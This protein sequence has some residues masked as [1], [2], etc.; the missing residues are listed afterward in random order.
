MA[1]DFKRI[2]IT[3]PEPRAGQA[4]AISAFLEAGGH[5]AHL[6]FPGAPESVMRRAI[7]EIAEGLRRR[8]RLHSHFSLAEEYGL[9]GV[10]LNS[11]WPNA[12]A[13]VAYSASCHSLEE[14]AS[15]PGADYVTLSP[16]Y[17][18]ISKSGYQGRYGP[19]A[20]KGK[21]PRKG[22]IALGGVTPDKFAEL[23]DAGFDGGML[24]GY[25]WDAP[26]RETLKMISK[27]FNS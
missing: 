1:K 22:V 24:L 8:L 9:G 27:C 4:E 19:A 11:R 17:D 14:L 3:A 20:V 7:E 16:V 12:P 18:S 26:A 15:H 10:H 5:M 6:R 25:V 23:S 2:L 13:G 21:L